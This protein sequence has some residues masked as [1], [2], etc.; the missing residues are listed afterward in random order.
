MTICV[1]QY[2]SPCDCNQPGAMVAKGQSIRVNALMMDSAQ[3]SVSTVYLDDDNGQ[4]AY[5]KSVTDGWKRGHTDTAG[6]DPEDEH[7]MRVANAWRMPAAD[8]ADSVSGCQPAG[9]HVADGDDYQARY[10]ART[11]NSW[12]GAQ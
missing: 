1:D 5:E 11:C 12:R 7:D 2:G 8:T 6:G 10:E 3:R 9:S 4:S